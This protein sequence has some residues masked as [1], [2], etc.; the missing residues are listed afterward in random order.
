MTLE[1]RI[2]ELSALPGP[3]GFEEKAAARVREVFA[4]VADE[5]WVDVMGNVIGLRRCGRK[6]ARRLL[7]DAHMDE[8]GL[9]V[10]GYEEG[11]LR[12][13]AIGSVDARMLPGAQVR[14]LT[15]P[16]V[17]GVI[18]VSPPHV[19]AKE[20]SDKA[21]QIEDLYIDAGL[22]QEE[23]V[24]KIPLGTPAVFDVTPRVFG[25]G[26]LTGKALDDR[27]CLA[28]VIEAM[29][30]LKD[31]PLSADVYLLA[32]TQEELGRRGVKTAAFDI[33]PDWCIVLDADHAKTPD[34]KRYDIRQAGGGVV[35]STGPNMSRDL[36][37]R[38]VRLAKEKG[39]PHQ[40][41]VEPGD[42][43]T[44]AAAVQI[45]RE[46]VATALLGIPVKYMHSP[47]ETLRLQDAKAA[48][49]LLAALIEDIAGEG[50]ENA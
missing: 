40:I 45:S 16:A 7:I 21:I 32:S 19:L 18:A 8:I 33:A 4:E 11:F 31:K 9:I 22:T 5:V 6:N 37:D 46:G 44:N 34:C 49:D 24:C 30:R 25:E 1:E 26:Y 14:L 47:V 12:F 23:A 17:T 15:E 28:V 27:A 29:G 36:T 38:A 43:G 13:A 3:A 20:D 42:S 48:V 41:G 50:R 10:T 39:I 2:L 35:I